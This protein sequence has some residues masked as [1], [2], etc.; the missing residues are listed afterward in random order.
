MDIMR[1]VMPLPSCPEGWGSS[2]RVSLLKHEHPMLRK[3]ETPVSVEPFLWVRLASAL[4]CRWLPVLSSSVPE[5][6][7]SFL[8]VT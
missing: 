2:Q 8:T 4:Y 1:M 5:A 6:Q 3:E 7:R